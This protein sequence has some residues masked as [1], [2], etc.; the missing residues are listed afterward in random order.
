MPISGNGQRK[1]EPPP[2]LLVMGIPL[3]AE[4]IHLSLEYS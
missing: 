2:E 3:L 4:L 1:K